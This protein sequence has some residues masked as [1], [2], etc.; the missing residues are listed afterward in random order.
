MARKARRTNKL[1]VISKFMLLANGCAVIALLLSYL[2][3]VVNPMG[4]WPIAFFGIA[5]LPLLVINIL[6]IIYWLIRRIPYAG[7][8][9]IAILVG[10]NTF[11]KHFGFS[12]RVP[13]DTVTA[14]DSA[15]IRLMTYNVHFFRTFEAQNNAP[16]I[17][18][19][20]MQVIDSISPDVVCIQEYYT[21]QRGQH[22]MSKAFK[23][24][25]GLPYRVV[26][27]AAQNDYEAYGLAIFSKYPILESGHLPD[28]QYGVNRVVYADINKNGKV[29]RV[30]NVHLRSIG[31]QKEDYDFIKRPAKTIEEDAASTRRIGSRLK[32]AFRARSGQAESLKAHSNACRVPF[33][34]AGDFNDTPLSYAVNQVSSGMQNAFLEKGRGWGVTYNG[35]FPNFQIDYILAS[36][37]FSI[38]WYQIVKKKLSDHYPVWADVVL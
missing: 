7:I 9:L 31:F 2:A 3:P 37:E 17:K 29:F 27:P 32:Q 28:H 1:G 4:F 15:A 12:A 22:R 11:N 18:D 10:W 38:Q 20:I 14:P 34:I 26:F 19:E 8:S 6:F 16:A 35:D 5:Y 25:V 36:K 21:R 33:I 13:A 30:Y 23:D 24:D